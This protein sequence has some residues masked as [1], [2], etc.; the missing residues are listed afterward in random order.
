MAR[1][2][3]GSRGLD[4]AYFPSSNSQHPFAQA[5]AGYHP[6]PFL[7]HSC[8]ISHYILK[9]SLL[10]F[11]FLFL[12]FSPF[13]SIPIAIDPVQATIT[14]HPESCMSLFLIDL[15]VFS[16][17]PLIYLLLCCQNNQFSSHIVAKVYI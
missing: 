17:S 5:Q 15:P 11:F 16:L 7:S 4:A 14:S 13:F 9:F 3:E 6:L 8:L 1:G 12:V 10:S 2:E